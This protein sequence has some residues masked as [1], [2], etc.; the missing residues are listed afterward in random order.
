VYERAATA[1]SPALRCGCRDGAIDEVYVRWRDGIASL[2]DEQ[3]AAPIAPRGGP[4]AADSMAARILPV[5]R[6]T[7]HHGGEIGL[8]RDLYRRQPVI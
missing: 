6:K 5:S 4:Y 7:M 8:L 2:D 3:P 1:L